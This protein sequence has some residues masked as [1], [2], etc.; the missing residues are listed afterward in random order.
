MTSE[1]AV[2]LMLIDCD[3][4][5]H[6]AYYSTGMLQHNGR[7]T[8]V[9]YGF[10]VALADLID[11]FA[12]AT[13][14]F[15]FDYGLPKRVSLFPAYKA[16]RRATGES[17]T[18]EEIEQRKRFDQQ[19]DELRH[20]MINSLGFQNV[21]YQRHYEADDLI[22]KLAIELSAHRVV[23]VSADSD[24]WQLLRPGLRIFNPINK[25]VATKKWFIKAY[26]IDPDHW[27]LV[28]AIA[29]CTSDNIPGVRGIGTASA[30]AY[31]NGALRH[32]GRLELIES[33]IKNGEIEQYL[34]L[35]RLP[36]K[37]VE[38]MRIRKERF[39]PQAWID[40]ATTIGS[41]VL[42]K[43]LPRI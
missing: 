42:K 10:M 8:G 31:L 43:H 7:P 17:R 29:G 26:G 41:P 13:I 18:R 2:D 24:L 6:R 4:M 35:T 16:N 33:A 36:M 34:A 38:S 11:R 15:C 20:R 1:P 19:R 5:C 37:G 22:A 27:A 25:R 30:I 28:K 21:F 3:F 14:G 32:T 40:L 23:I 39:D 12:P 9:I